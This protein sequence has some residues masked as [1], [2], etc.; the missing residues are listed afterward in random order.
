MFTGPEVVA[1]PVCF[2]GGRAVLSLNLLFLFLTF[3]A[4]F[5]PPASTLRGVVITLSLV[6]VQGG[7]IY[8]PHALKKQFKLLDKLQN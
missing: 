4:N 6:T 5:R 1:L 3:E 2:L 8:N 7:I